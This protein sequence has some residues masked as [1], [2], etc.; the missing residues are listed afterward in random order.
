MTRIILADDV[1]RA[2][3]RLATLPTQGCVEA[4][5]TRRPEAC[6]DFH[7][8]LVP[9]AY[10]PF[11]TAV[12]VAYAEH[13][14]LVLSP[15]MIWLVIAQ[16]FANIVHED[17][18]G[19][20][21]H[22]VQHAGRATLE[23]RR[24]EFVKGSPENDWAGVYAE[25]SEKIRANIGAENHASMLVDF[26]TTGPVERAA[27]EVVLMSGMR[28]YYTFELM[29]LCGIP[30]VRLE[31]TVDDWALLVDRTRNLGSRYGCGWWIDRLV[32]YVE[33][34]AAC[35]SGADDHELWQ[36]I[37]KPPDESGDEAVTGWILCLFPFF[38]MGK[39]G[40]LMKNPLLE[41]RPYAATSRTWPG[42][43]SLAPFRW[44]YYA[45]VYEKDFLAGFVGITQEPESLALRP[46]IGWAVV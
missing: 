18:E 33:R 8:Q 5:T 3:D 2:Q 14:P 26:T 27:N 40:T 28:N 36:T 42:A 17:P 22:F 32:E 11:V 43:L 31:G 19:M 44:Q 16:G 9:C 12:E 45:E 7:D 10:H 23:V 13:H 4:L 30:E 24:D 1:E 25:F 37:Y 46:K 41:G 21:E 29:T 38:Q 15:D 39:D 6:S 34:M 35:A 20:R